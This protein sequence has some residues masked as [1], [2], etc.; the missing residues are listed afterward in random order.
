MPSPAKKTKVK[1]VVV[2]AVLLVFAASLA[3]YFYFKPETKV[4]YFYLPTCPSCQAV[5]PYMTYLEDK[6]P[7][8]K[9]QKY[10]LREGEGTRE[11]EYL[12]KKLGNAEGGVPFAVLMDNQTTGFLGR[13]EVLNLEKAICGELDINCPNQTYEVPPAAQSDCMECHKKRNLPPPSRY[14]C[15]A[16]CHS[17]NVEEHI[18]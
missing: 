16:C 18:N 2:L 6:Y 3:T 17:L 15:E 1:P 8:I 10:N 12:S 4:L 9:F 14:T 7:M 5:K 11:F 13:G